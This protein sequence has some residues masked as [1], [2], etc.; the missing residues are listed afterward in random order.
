VNWNEYRA[1]LINQIKELGG[2]DGKTGLI[3]KALGP[4]EVHS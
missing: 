1:S 2:A 3:V 4:F